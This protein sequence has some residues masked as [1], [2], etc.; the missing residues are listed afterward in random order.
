MGWNRRNFAHEFKSR[1]ET[2][3]IAKART[4][5]VRTSFPSSSSLSATDLLRSAPTY[6][7]L[8]LILGVDFS[9]SAL[10]QLALSDVQD[11]L[12]FKFESWSTRVLSQPVQSRVNPP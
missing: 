3:E 8:M 10:L 5:F 9:R 7:S 1:L 6:G 11:L 2:A 4:V 12:F